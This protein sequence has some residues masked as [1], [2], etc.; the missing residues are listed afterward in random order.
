MTT[1]IKT[2]GK[3]QGKF[4]IKGKIIAKTGLHVGGSKSALSIGEIDMNVI[5]TPDGK[6][7]I[8]GSSLKGKMRSILA[9]IEGCQSV[10]TDL[11]YIKEIFGESGD[12][13]KQQTLAIFRDCIWKKPK[14]FDTWELEMD[15]TESKWET[16][17]DR[18]KGTAKH[19]SLR[20]IERIPAGSEFELN[21]VV[22]FLSPNQ[23]MD[24]EIKMEEFQLLHRCLSESGKIDDCNK[25]FLIY[26]IILRRGL[27][28]I[29][30]DFIG[31]HGSRGYGKVE[32]EVDE[33]SYK[34]IDDYL[35]NDSMKSIRLDW[36]NKLLTNVS[37]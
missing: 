30:D 12:R 21:I 19:G 13:A 27:A 23:F 22:D 25:R 37:C 29:E 7:Y 14:D 5:K 16:A 1:E 6:P 4:F 20:Q 26:L 9:K 17:I 18:M 34:S 2:I 24:S 8:P 32:I 28:L 35:K 3:L 11:P 15:Y 33:I 10:E 36:I 31:G